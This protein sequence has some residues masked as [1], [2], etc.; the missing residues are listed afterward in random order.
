MRLSSRITLALIAASLTDNA[1]I[2]SV[3]LAISD[4]EVYRRP[5]AWSENKSQ[6]DTT[7]QWAASAVSRPGVSIAWR[8]A[9]QV[10]EVEVRVVN[11]GDEPGEGRISVHVV[12]ATGKILLTLTPPEGQEIL[13]VPARSKGGLQGKVIRMKANWELNALID[14]NDLTRTQYGVMATVETIGKDANLFDNRK[15]KTWNVPFRVRPETTNVFNY[16]FVNHEAES[17]TLRWKLD[18]TELPEGWILE[19]APDEKLTIELKPGESVNGTMMLRA[20]HAIKQ[21]EYLESRIALVDTKSDMVYRQHEWFQVFDEIPPEISNY[22]AIS[23][24]DGT[25][26]IQALVADRHSG[27]LEATGVSTQFSVDDGKTWAQKSHNYKVGN[28]ITPTLFETVLGPFVKGTKIQVRMTA[29]DTAGNAQAIIPSDA[30][31]FRAP[32]GAEKLIQLAYIFPRTKANPIFEVEK[33]KELT[34]AVRNLNRNG[35][36]VQSIDLKKPNALQISSARLR[37]LGYDETRLGDLRSDLQKLNVLDLDT[38]GIVSVP[39]SRVQSLG[40]SIL[41]VSTLEIQAQ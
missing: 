30:S 20:P 12:D 15:C 7:V 9:N 32:T 6:N 33:L 19:G 21:G 35:V 5:N 13:R 31:V 34:A 29:K 39:I 22:R 24:A 41:N 1:A 25:I 17:K 36:N 2:A 4:D 14:R 8:N 3:D 37:E 40:E 18:R 28:F 16:S 23:L 38:D 11:F 27:V 10:E 26:A